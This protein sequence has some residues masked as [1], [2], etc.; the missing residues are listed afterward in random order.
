MKLV[1]RPEPEDVRAL[2]LT[3][4]RRLGRLEEAVRAQYPEAAC[5]GLREMSRAVRE[6]LLRVQEETCQL[7]EQLRAG[8]DDADRLEDRLTRTV[9]NLTEAAETFR[10]TFEDLQQR[11][12]GPTG[13][14]AVQ[15]IHFPP[16][17]SRAIEGASDEASVSALSA[18]LT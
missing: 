5:T 10:E 4:L 18:L 7:V 14:S 8:P 17:Q 12:G 6:D 11:G 9:F 2:V 13:S 15:V 3:V 16:R 1:P